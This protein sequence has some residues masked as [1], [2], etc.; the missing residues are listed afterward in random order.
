VD[1]AIRNEANETAAIWQAN[2]ALREVEF[3]NAAGG[4]QATAKALAMPSGRDVW[5]ISA[6][7]MAARTTVR[8]HS[9][10]WISS[11]VE[12]P[13]DLLIQNYWLPV[14]RAALQFARGG[15]QRS[16]EILST[17]SGYDLAVPLP[18]QLGT[19]YPV[20]VR[21]Q[22]HLK[23]GAGKRRRPNSRKSLI[24]ADWYKNFPLG[25]LAHFGL[26]RAYARAGDSTKA[27][28]AY[29]DAFALWKSADPFLS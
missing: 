12:F 28:A 23:A 7:T 18:F 24:A 20:Y 2:S 22:A 9:R 16:I 15:A 5:V 3:G 17:S 11:T 26:A 29:Q 25:A 1:S 21:G 14:I 13:L 4:R 6:L 19:M 10:S 8:K 27:R